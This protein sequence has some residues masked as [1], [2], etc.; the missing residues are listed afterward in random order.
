MRVQDIVLTPRVTEKSLE[1]GTKSV[2]SFF[3][4]TKASKHQIKER[5]ESLFGV[6]VGEI[7]TFMRKGKVKRVGKKRLL[8]AGSDQKIANIEILKGDV[9]VFPKA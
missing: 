8:K 9:S 5:I 2:V 7:R 4:A 6:T 1:A 3:V